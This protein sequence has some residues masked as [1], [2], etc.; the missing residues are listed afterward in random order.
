MKLQ[1]VVDTIPIALQELA[2]AGHDRVYVDQLGQQVTSHEPEYLER[3]SRISKILS[4]IGI[5]ID[6]MP[7]GHMRPGAYKMYR[8]LGILEEAGVIVGEFEEP[9]DDAMPVR[10]VYSLAPPKE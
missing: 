3:R 10:R 7:P 6:E 4:A 1:Q 9:K 8:S 2:D 5:K